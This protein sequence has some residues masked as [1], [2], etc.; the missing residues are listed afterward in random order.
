LQDHFLFYQISNRGNA[1]RKGCNGARLIVNNF[2]ARGGRE[3]T[4]QKEEQ[5]G[6]CQSNQSGCV[7]HFWFDFIDSIKIK[8]LLPA[9]IST[10]ENK[11]SSGFHAFDLQI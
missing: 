6:G 5:D 4:V 3:E 8:E 7:F 1:K 11:K 2:F 9:I 10:L